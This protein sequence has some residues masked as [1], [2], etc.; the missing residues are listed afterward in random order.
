MT[1]N[2]LQG[3]GEHHRLRLVVQS[4][5]GFIASANNKVCT[6]YVLRKG[7]VLSRDWDGSNMGYR[8]GRVTNMI[9]ELSALGDESERRKLNISGMRKIQLDYTSGL[10]MVHLSAKWLMLPKKQ[11]THEEQ[12]KLSRPPIPRMLFNP[13]TFSG[14]MMVGDVKPTI[15]VR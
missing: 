1:K 13:A 2:A 9:E 8:G 5:R 7:Y 12:L 14:E 15:F 6:W 10:W 11:G 4:C 3:L